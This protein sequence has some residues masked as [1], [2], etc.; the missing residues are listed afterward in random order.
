MTYML[1][2][3]GTAPYTKEELV[4]IHRFWSFR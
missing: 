1:A 3:M 2:P 4:G